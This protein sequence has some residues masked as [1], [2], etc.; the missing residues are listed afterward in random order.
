[1]RLNKNKKTSKATIAHLFFGKTTK[2]NQK[3]PGE[4]LSR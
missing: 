2:H 4:K 3:G 1:M